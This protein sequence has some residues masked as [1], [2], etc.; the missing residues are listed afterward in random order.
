MNR[1][2]LERFEDNFGHSSFSLFENYLD[3]SNITVFMH[4]HNRLEIIHVIDGEGIVSV[5]LNEYPVSSGDIVLISPNQIHAVSG[6]KNHILH[7]Q[8]IV[9][10]VDRFGLE[11]DCSLQTHISAGSPGNSD[12]CTLHTLIFDLYIR[13]LPDAQNVLQGLLASLCYLI[14]YH[15][16]ALPMPPTAPASAIA[17]KEVLTYMRKNFTHTIDIDTLAEIAGY[18]KYHFIRFF[19]HAT[20]YT[21]IQYLHMLRLQKAKKLLRTTDYKLD[22]ISELSGFKSVSY[23]IRIFKRGEGVTPLQ[24]RKHSTNTDWL[25]HLDRR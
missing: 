21:C 3:D 19:S 11:E 24:Y 20:G 18:S 14:P 2:T 8:T 7:C 16:F 1:P 10:Q 15:H 22:Y 23:F 12:F 17:L 6:Q 13:G 5:N 4:Y 25:P 9:F